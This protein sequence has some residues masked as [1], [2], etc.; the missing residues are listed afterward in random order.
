MRVSVLSYKMPE[1]SGT[2]YGVFSKLPRHDQLHDKRYFET[3]YY[4]SYQ[5][6][7]D[8]QRFQPKTP[9]MY[10]T[11]KMFSGTISNYEPF[12]KIKISTK[13][14]SEKYNSKQ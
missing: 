6:K 8:Q 3:T 4:A 9:A 12:N 10:N 5:K 1:L 7:F 13:L 14:I 2:K 11:E